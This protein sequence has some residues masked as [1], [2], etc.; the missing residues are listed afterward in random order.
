MLALCLMLSGTY[1][2]RNYAGMIG[3]SLLIKMRTIEEGNE[4]HLYYVL[5]NY[6]TLLFRINHNEIQESHSWNN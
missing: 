3:A 5:Y 4:V 6:V 1:Y 2:A